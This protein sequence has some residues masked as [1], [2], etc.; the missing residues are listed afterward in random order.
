MIDLFSPLLYQRKSSR[1][2][3]INQK[4]YNRW[5]KVADFDML[6]GK[7][8]SQSFCDYFDINDYILLYG[9]TSINADRYIRKTYLR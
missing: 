3:A 4:Q 5:R 8:L 2:F 1:N 7:T 9:K 6:K